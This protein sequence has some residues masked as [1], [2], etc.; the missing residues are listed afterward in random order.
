MFGCGLVIR[1][2]FLLFQAVYDNS[3]SSRPLPSIT[4]YGQ[5]NKQKLAVFTARE[6]L[7]LLQT[8]FAAPDG[9][10]ASKRSL[11]QRHGARGALGVN[12]LKGL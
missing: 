3:I 5:T 10:A 8:V 11:K 6:N 1:S 7:D 9:P 12:G 4:I 2:S